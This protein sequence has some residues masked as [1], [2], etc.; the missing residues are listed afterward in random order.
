MTKF[1]RTYLA[2]PLFSALMMSAAMGTAASAGGAATP[3]INNPADVAA[4]KQIGTT[5]GDAMVAK[6]IDKLK[7]IYAEDW[8]S[9]GR[10]G[11]TMNRDDVLQ[12]IQTGSHQLVSYKLGPIDVE[13]LGN[14]A[15]AGGR[16]S[17]VRKR[18]GKD[19]SMNVIY[20]DYL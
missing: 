3:E 11:K 16:V 19:V 13:V 17:E 5:M 6:D 2:V 1:S 20:M 8:M 15:V 10:S 4:I 14:V 12:D 9:V 18:D 7:Q